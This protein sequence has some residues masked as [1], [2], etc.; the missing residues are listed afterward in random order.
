MQ[1]LRTTSRRTALVMLASAAALFADRTHA[2]T[3]PVAIQV[4]KDPSCGCC[5][6]WVAHITQNGFVPAVTTTS[7]MQAVKVRHGVPDD[8]ASCHTALVAGYVIE[9]HVPADAIRRLLD[10]KPEAIGLSAPGM[11]IG[12]PGMEGGE[13]E[14][15]D[16]VLFTK[17]SRRS[18]GRYKGAERV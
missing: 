18:F 4:F 13:P 11:P 10:E 14:A 1:E 5:D 9:G 2:G 3:P 6:G 7:R 12:S 17:S 16:V 15:F 8:L